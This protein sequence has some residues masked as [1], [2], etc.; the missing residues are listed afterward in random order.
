M[1]ANMDDLSSYFAKVAYVEDQN[2]EDEATAFTNVAVDF[3]ASPVPEDSAKSQ[4]SWSSRETRSTVEPKP[5]TTRKTFAELFDSLPSA[6]IPTAAAA[7]VPEERSKFSMGSYRVQRMSE[8]IPASERKITYAD[9]LLKP[10]AAASA[11][12]Q[13]RVILSETAADETAVGGGAGA[14]HD[15]S[16]DFSNSDHELSFGVKNGAEA[17]KKAYEN[18]EKIQIN[19]PIDRANTLH[20]FAT[21]SATNPHMYVIGS[22]LNDAFGDTKPKRMMVINKKT[23]ET[24][25]D[26]SWVDHMVGENHDTDVI[27]AALDTAGIVTKHASL[28]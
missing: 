18:N 23:R 13:K 1:S 24:T 26:E 5:T 12:T 16:D 15:F 27:R 21:P 25:E 10:A 7:V 19:L 17:L 6:E 4:S 22:K 8:P 11:S 28:I 3:E 9:A 2:D 14:A 20:L